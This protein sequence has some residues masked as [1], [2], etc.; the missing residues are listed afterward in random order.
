MNLTRV[1]LEATADQLDFSYSLTNAGMFAGLET[2]IGIIVSCMPTF[3]PIFSKENNSYS[4]RQQR[5]YKASS[6]RTAAHESSRKRNKVDDSFDD[7]D[8]H[9]IGDDAIPLNGASKKVVPHDPLAHRGAAW[10]SP[11]ESRTST[12]FIGEEGTPSGAIR[13]QSEVKVFTSRV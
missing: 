2:F 12:P 6:S 10:V 3:G 1:I 5:A 8:F 4:S 13:V 11:G 9:R 7:G